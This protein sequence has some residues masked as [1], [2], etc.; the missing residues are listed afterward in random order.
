MRSLRTALYWSHVAGQVTRKRF[1]VNCFVFA[2]CRVYRH[3]WIA[4]LNQQRRENAE[5][6]VALDLLPW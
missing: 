6:I 2:L 1:R 4:W 3:R 5:N